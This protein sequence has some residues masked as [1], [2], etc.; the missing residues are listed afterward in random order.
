ML[1]AGLVNLLGLLFFS[2]FFG[3]LVPVVV[4]IQDS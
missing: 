1:Q 4:V 3:Q 2:L